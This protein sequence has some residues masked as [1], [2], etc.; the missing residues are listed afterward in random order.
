VLNPCAELVVMVAR[1]PFCVAPAGLAAM[2]T[3]AGCVAPAGL[4]AIAT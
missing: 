1:K 2:A 3:A 4:A